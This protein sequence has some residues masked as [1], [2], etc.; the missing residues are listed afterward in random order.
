MQISSGFVMIGLL[1]QELLGFAKIKC[2]GLFSPA[3]EILNCNLVYKFVLT[4]YR[5]ALWS[6]THF[7]VSYCFL[8]FVFA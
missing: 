3:L 5:S 4:L 2:S 8:F 1:L 7:N 6:L